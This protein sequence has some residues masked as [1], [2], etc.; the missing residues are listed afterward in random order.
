M[1]AFLKKYNLLGN[2]GRNAEGPRD[3]QWMKYAEYA[4]S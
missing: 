3:F 1:D 4:V 2:K